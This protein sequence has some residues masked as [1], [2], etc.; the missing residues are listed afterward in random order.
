MGPADALAPGSRRLS[1]GSRDV[2]AAPATGGGQGV[3]IIPIAVPV[4]MGLGR[5]WAYLVVDD[6][7]TLIDGGP[8]TDAAY[9]AIRDGLAVAGVGIGAL[10]RIVITHAHVGHCGLAGRLHADSGARV[11]AH[12]LALAALADAREAWAGRVDLAVRAA[13]AGGVSADAI[14]AYA[15]LASGRAA[16]VA[17]VPPD[18]MEPLAHGA[19]IRFAASGAWRAFHAPGHSPDHLVLHDPS[20]GSA[21]A[22]DLLLRSAP[23][24]TALEPRRSDGSRPTTLDDLVA[25]WRALGRRSAR[26]VHPGHGAPIRAHRVL[27]ARRLAECRASLAAARDAVRGGA[28]TLW[29]VARSTGRSTAPED[30]GTTLG[31]VVARLDALVRRGLIERRTAD[32]TLRFAVATRRR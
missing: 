12:P 7:L 21:F 10:R 24:T 22:G 17:P 25:S 3:P 28:A 29:E 13:A 4:P 31:D 6:P 18:A 2:F 30:L 5:V 15:R 32:G 8:N 11:A 16:L 14:E 9:A 19:S 1:D 20:S 26:V 27:L 23:T